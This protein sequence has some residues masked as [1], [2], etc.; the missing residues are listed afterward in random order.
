MVHGLSPRSAERPEMFVLDRGGSISSELQRMWAEPWLTWDELAACVGNKLWCCCKAQRLP[1]CCY[2]YN[3]WPD[4]FRVPALLP[5]ES[6]FKKYS[7]VAIS[8][9]VLMAAFC[10]TLE[11]RP[12]H[13]IVIKPHSG[14]R[15]KPLCRCL[16]MLS[17][18]NSSLKCTQFT[19]H[20]N[21]SI[22][23]ILL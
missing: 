21:S 7:T 2:I 9:T 18:Y 15:I 16:P 20:W 13:F 14:L 19:A 22:W 8:I 6:F 10:W 17:P 12:K 4:R 5:V 11:L 3:T 23:W 1:G